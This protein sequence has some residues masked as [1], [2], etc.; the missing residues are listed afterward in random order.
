MESV[1]DDFRI[2]GEL[3]RIPNVRNIHELHV[4]QLVDGLTIASV[5]VV[6]NRS[7]PWEQVGC[8]ECGWMC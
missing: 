8:V 3:K 6:V 2:R 5:H 4:W 7:A 1:D